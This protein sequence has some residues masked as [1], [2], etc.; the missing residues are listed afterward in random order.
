MSAIA[1]RDVPVAL[2]RHEKRVRPAQ[3][4]NLQLKYVSECVLCLPYTP[5]EQGWWSSYIYLGVP[6]T[7]P[8]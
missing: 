3:K 8:G 1:L 4:S 6:D 2:M 7:G 5:S